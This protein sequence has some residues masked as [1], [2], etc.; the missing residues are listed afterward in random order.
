MKFR[1]VD[2]DRRVFLRTT[3]LATTAVAAWAATEGTVR[4]FG[5]AGAERRFTGSHE[6]SPFDP[7]D[8]PV[9]QW[10]DDSVQHLDPA[11]WRLALPQG[12]IGLD[13]LARMPTEQFL[14]TL[15]CTGGWHS[16]QTWAGVRLDHLIDVGEHRSIDVSSATGYGR[17]FPARDLDRL[18][19][20]THMGDRPLTPGHGAPVR[21]VAPGRR[22]FWWVKWVVAIN[23]SNVPWWVQL[24]FPAT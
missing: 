18:W 12:P 14:A 9:T 22:G 7:S 2:L 21:L 1:T 19:L 15:D 10:F 16:P 3:A 24:P 17:R 4:A 20:V 8:V 11:A 23:P 5:W 13:E 6:V